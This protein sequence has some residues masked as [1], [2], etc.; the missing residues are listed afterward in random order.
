MKTRMYFLG[1]FLLAL[2]MGV[3]A[4]VKLNEAIT[5]NSLT[6][7]GKYTITKSETPMVVNELAVT[8]YE[9]KY[10]NTANPVRIG[11]VKEKKCTT[12][13][14]KSEQ[15]EVQYSC[16]KG[17]FGVQ[18]MDKKYRE[19]PAVACDSKFNKTSFYAQ[20]V[21]CQS[22]KTEEELLGL[23]ACYFPNLVEEQYHAQF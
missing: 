20:R 14:V 9:L 6:D 17:S 15:F 11:V 1:I 12:F 18:K 2:V 22:L 4:R 21:I 5:G 8:T 3:S 19:L 10:E 13:L 7:F 23:I 16:N